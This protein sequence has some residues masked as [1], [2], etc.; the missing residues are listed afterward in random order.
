M[1]SDGREIRDIALSIARLNVALKSAGIGP[2]VCIGLPRAELHV[3]SFLPKFDDYVSNSPIEDA[4]PVKIA[5]VGF[6]AY[7]RPTEAPPP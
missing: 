3:L 4:K 1:S 7:E 2:A 5:G 6:I